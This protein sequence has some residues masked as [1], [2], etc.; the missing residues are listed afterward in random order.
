MRAPA[1]TIRVLRVRGRS[2]AWPIFAL[3]IASVLVATAIYFVVTF[4]GPPPRDPPHGIEGIAFLL[5]TGEQPGGRGQRL[6]LREDSAPPRPRDNEQANIP[7]ARKIAAALG[8][9]HDQV[10]AF[11][12]PQPPWLLD[13]FIDGFSIGWRS[14]GRW[15]IVESPPRM[16]FT[17]WH[18]I[19][20]ASMLA[21]IL[22]LAI[23]A[24]GL[25]RAISRPL[26][27]LAR[28]AEDAR[29][30]TALAPLPTGGS[31]EVRE[32]AAALSTMHGRL[33]RH[34]EGRTTM[35]GAIA[36]DLGTPLSRLAFWV[37]Q[38]PDE[39]RTRAIADIDEM[40]A[41][42]AGALRFARDEGGEQQA[43]R[44][45]L[46]SLLDSLAEDMAVAGAAVALVPG[47]RAVVRG[48]P[49]AL[50]RLFVNLVE[51]A[52]RY[53]MSAAIGWRI[54][55]GSVEVTV[56]DRGPGIDPT[57]AERLFEAF[58]RGDPS[59]N[60][61]TGGTGLGLAIVRSIATRHGGEAGLENRAGPGKDRGARAWVTLPLSS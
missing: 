35:L 18:W 46:G 31:R 44:V 17:R 1:A 48:D 50:R 9:P 5:R 15:H 49:G 29:A 59:R 34:A 41:M 54:V 53:G 27:R 19:T 26:R 55:G 10:V 13:A 8:V 57:Q 12:A 30:G 60:R 2:I 61:S 11:A 6:R 40:R 23:P 22:A 51:N 28:A 7:A 43:V 58:V 56:D 37:E 20:L 4:S 25:S 24:W 47:P 52:V 38:L 36:H 45:D 42:I 32:L 14:D 39:S 16:V 21:A 3:V 33:A